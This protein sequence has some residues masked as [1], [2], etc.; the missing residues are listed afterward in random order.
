MKDKDILEALT[1]LLR[2]EHA[3]PLT[4]EVVDVFLALPVEEDP[5]AIERRR[6]NFAIAIIS[7]LHQEPVRKIEGKRSFGEWIQ[8]IR[9][10]ARLTREAIAAAVQ[11]DTPFIERLET[12]RTSPFKLDPRDISELI[13]LFRLHIDGLAQLLANT[14]AAASENMRRMGRRPDMGSAVTGLM[15]PDSEPPVSHNSKTVD[16][17]V[18]KLLAS[19]R[20]D[21]RQRQATHLLE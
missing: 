7:E 13:C 2:S 11:K 5:H 9:G 18:D 4:D 6:A 14:A 16:K 12:G 8:S 3:P 10:K 17:K 1:V 19:V 15:D 21:L 20:A